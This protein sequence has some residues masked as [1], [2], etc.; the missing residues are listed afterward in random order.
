MSIVSM[1]LA[2]SILLLTWMMSGSSK[3]RTTW[4]MTPT[5]RMLARNLLPRPSPLEAPATRPAMST[6]CVVAG[7]T[8][9]VGISWAILSKRGSGTLTMPML[10]S[11]V[12]K[13]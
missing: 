12:Q 1:S 7:M 13:G 9:A 8:L 2:G 11:M 6:N 4:A 3:Q 5:S 10:G